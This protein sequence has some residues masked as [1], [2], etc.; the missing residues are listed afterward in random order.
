MYLDREG[1]GNYTRM[2]YNIKSTGLEP[3]T[4]YGYTPPSGDFLKTNYGIPGYPD[5]FNAVKFRNI[6]KFLGTEFH[7][8]RT[9]EKWENAA[10]LWDWTQNTWVEI[11]SYQ[12]WSDIDW[13]RS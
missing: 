13:N 4:A 6:A 9:M 10:G 8:G 5:S 11:Y 7:D 2:L 1:D 3:I 12:Y